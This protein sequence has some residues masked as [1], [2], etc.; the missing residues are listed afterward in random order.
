MK[1]LRGFALCVMGV[2]AMGLSACGYNK[3]SEV[4]ALNEAQAVGS[5]FTQKLASEYRIFVNREFNEMYDHP[6][7]IH[8]ARKGLAAAA[9]DAV[10]PEP[11]SDWNL[12]P[13]HIEELGTA[14]GRLLAAYDIGAREL[15]PEQSAIA[16]TRFDCWIEQQEE[17]WQAGDIAGCKNDFLAAMDAL[18]G[19]LSVPAPEPE[20]LPPVEPVVMDAPEPM[21]PEDAMYLV[22]FDFDSTEI[23]AGGNNVLDAVAEEFKGKNTNVIKVV[24]HTDAAGP[25][26]YNNRLAMKR[27]NA[28]R[29]ALAVRGVDAS[30]IRV[31]GRGEDELL[32][33]TA[34]GVREPANRR[35]QITFE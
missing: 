4:D 1:K 23:G 3:H 13:K 27:A 35:A 34:D 7:A 12:M 24:G 10:L 25:K 16:Q 21:K 33:Q 2:C 29:D 32:V 9:G 19:M 8:F 28:V 17:N 22:F 30:I 6:D 18:E 14:R 5:P 15:A 11:V 26:S 31:E 20:F